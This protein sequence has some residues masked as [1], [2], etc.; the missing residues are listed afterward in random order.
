MCNTLNIKCYIINIMLA[1]NITLQYYLIIMCNILNI[2]SIMCNTSY[3]YYYYYYYYPFI[4]FADRIS[5]LTYVF[6][7]LKTHCKCGN[8]L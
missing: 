3:H 6:I 7:L 1:L 5:Y 2:L 4:V 8:M